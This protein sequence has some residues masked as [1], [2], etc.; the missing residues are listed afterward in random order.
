ME[1]W[2]GRNHCLQN[3]TNEYDYHGLRSK[4]TG[5]GLYTNSNPLFGPMSP[6][7]TYLE[8]M[9]EFLCE[10]RRR[11]TAKMYTANREI[12]RGKCNGVGMHF[13]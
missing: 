4:K 10:D 5:L 11:L 7:S 12:W 8:M 9:G 2:L 1:E 13:L 3:S 6:N